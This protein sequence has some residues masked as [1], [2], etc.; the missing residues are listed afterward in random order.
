MS[1][2]FAAAGVASL[3]SSLYDRLVKTVIGPAIDKVHE[4]ERKIDLHYVIDQN[5]VSSTLF[6]SP[7]LTK[8]DA[9]PHYHNRHAV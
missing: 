1:K 5:P 8:S 9:R 3:S 7:N 4:E 6:L 2:L